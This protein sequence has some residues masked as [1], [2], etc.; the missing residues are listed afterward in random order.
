[1]S[2]MS[3]S[4]RTLIRPQAAVIVA[5]ACLTIAPVAGAQVRSPEPMP[6]Q[7][8]AARVALPP[9]TPAH[10]RPVLADPR[11]RQAQDRLDT[12]RRVTESER[13]HAQRMQAL[14][15]TPQV[16]E[17]RQ[18]SERLQQ[19]EARRE[20][21]LLRERDAA[22]REARARELQGRPVR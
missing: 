5:A 10:V 7:V 13:G 8:D 1:M 15:A 22:V 12:R 21:A 19:A 14:G 6:R 9:P 17:T 4:R 20:A 16:Q 2:S 18:A 11:V 3:P